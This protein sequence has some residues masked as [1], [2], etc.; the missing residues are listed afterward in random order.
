M[1]EVIGPACTCTCALDR[2]W[3]MVFSRHHVQ[4]L[5]GFFFTIKHTHTK[6]S[7][8]KRST[9]RLVKQSL[10]HTQTHTSLQINR[11]N[12]PAHIAAITAP[13][14][15]EREREKHNEFYITQDPHIQPPHTDEKPQHTP[16]ETLLIPE[17]TAGWKASTA[18]TSDCHHR[19]QINRWNNRNL[20][21]CLIIS[22]NDQGMFPTNHI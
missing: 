14:W 15:R 18:S 19:T 3:N 7:R 10:T 16:C 4:T 21:K 6:L 12:N 8:S 13:Q 5:K 22:S 11:A 17:E 1:Q 9:G 20:T 2:H